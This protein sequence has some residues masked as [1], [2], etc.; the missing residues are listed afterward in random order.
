MTTYSEI[1]FKL[2]YTTNSKTY[3][4]PHDWTISHFIETITQNAR[5]DFE[6]NADLELV[7][8]DLSE[9]GEALTP[10]NMTFSQKY[11]NRIPYLAFYVRPV[12]RATI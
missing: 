7:D 9:N 5:L 3:S 4:I 12:C 6:M 8:V 2:A 11:M 10:E 1:Y